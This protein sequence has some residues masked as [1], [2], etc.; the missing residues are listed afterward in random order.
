MR[1]EVRDGWPYLHP[2]VYVQGLAAGLHRNY[3]GDICL[4]IDGDPSL[5][6]L[7]WDGIARRIEKWAAEAAAT[8]TADDPAFDAHL[9]FEGGTK[10]LATV[11]LTGV[12][13]RDGELRG[14]RGTLRE[15]L[16]QI[17]DG[18]LRGRLYSRAAITTPPT[19]LAAVRR[20]LRRRQ[21]RDLSQALSSVGSPDGV[22]FLI[23]AW[24]T[25]VGPNLLVLWLER[26]NGAV[27]A[28]SFEG[29]RIDREILLLRAGPDGR[30]LSR[31]RVAVLGLGA[32]GSHLAQLLARCGVGTLAVFDQQRLRPGDVVRHVASSQFVGKS[33]VAAV[34]AAIQLQAPWTEVLDVERSHWEPSQLAGIARNVDLVV[35]AVGS[36]SFTV[37]LARVCD[38]E[39]RR[40]LAVSLYHHGDVV[41]V[42][43]QGAPPV[44]NLADRA[45]DRAFPTIPPDVDE[46]EAAW[47]A[48]CGAPITQATPTAVAS[49]AAA[50]ARLAV[51]V[52][53]GRETGDLDLV[54]V[55]R[56]LA[57]PPFD[58]VGSRMFRSE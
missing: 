52:L 54:E 44:A 29:A 30:E 12:R 41:R 25:G 31:R 21:Q 26:T 53:C 47:E 24:H 8:A 17:G 50:A 3:H 28:T 46:E 5:E 20:V 58:V 13:V 22:S 2:K 10:G 37:Q 42:R 57:S 33:K 23:L 11:D 48:G 39:S 38:I 19:D 51:E 43:H 27:K 7:R 18:P 15:G 55:Y 1:V 14:V 40:L 36:A 49:A 9:Y 32:V 4:W 6:W 16:L 35:D 45:A 34:K 56:P